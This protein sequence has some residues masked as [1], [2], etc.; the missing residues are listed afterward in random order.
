M[1]KFLL[2]QT[3]SFS[4]VHVKIQFDENLFIKM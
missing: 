3:L 4:V 2:Q 1:E